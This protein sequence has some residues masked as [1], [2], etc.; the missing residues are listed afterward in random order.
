MTDEEKIN[1]VTAKLTGGF[2]IGQR[3]RHKDPVVARQWTGVIVDI[4]PHMLRLSA[5][6]VRD[7]TTSWYEKESFEPFV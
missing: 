2:Y 6:G 1:A 7:S 4:S 5:Y 3:V